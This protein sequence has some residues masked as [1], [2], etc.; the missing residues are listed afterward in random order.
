MTTTTKARSQN[1]DESQDSPYPPSQ[2]C[3]CQS[4]NEHV[5]AETEVKA[6]DGPRSILHQQRNPDND[7]MM[8]MMMTADLLTQ[9]LLTGV[10]PSIE[11]DTRQ[12]VDLEREVKKIYI[13]THDCLLK[14]THRH[15][16]GNGLL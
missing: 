10:R 11:S 1:D 12:K 9:I 5:D 15:Y 7:L 13:Q 3:H 4:K 6:A 14:Y 8:I 2:S 16:R